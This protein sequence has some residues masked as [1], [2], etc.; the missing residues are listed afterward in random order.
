M[1]N[2]FGVIKSPQTLIVC[3]HN[4]VNTVKITELRG[5]T[6]MVHE[7]CFKIIQGSGHSSVVECLLSIL[8]VLATLIK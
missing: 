5:M 6:F 8:K 3:L 2:N 1:G 7:L 4:L